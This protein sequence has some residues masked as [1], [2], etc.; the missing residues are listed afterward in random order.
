MCIAAAAVPM[1]LMA[2]GTAISA[3][4]T[5]YSGIQQN[6]VAKANAKAAEMEAKQQRQI[7]RVQEMQ[8]RDRMRHAIAR[9]RAGLAASGINLASTSS[10]D[11]GAEAGEQAFLDAQAVRTSSDARARNLEFEARLAR[12]GGRMAMFGGFAR[13]AATGLSGAGQ[14]LTL[15]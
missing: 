6:N 2:A 10:V 9:Q 1:V 7:G 14:A 4:A 8:A 3:G 13:G 5:I 12:A 11:L 15:A